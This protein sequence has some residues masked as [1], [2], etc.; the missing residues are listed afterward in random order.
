MES[1]KTDLE[2]NEAE[3]QTII[4]Q[5]QEEITR[6]DGDIEAQKSLMNKFTVAREEAERR[7][8]EISRQEMG[9]ANA[10]VRVRIRKMERY[11]TPPNIRA[12]SCGRY[13]P[14]VLSRMN[15]V[16]EMLL[17]REQVHIIRDLI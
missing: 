3:L 14:E 1:V 12:N 2:S 15:L 4:D 13:R 16:T 17:Q 7:I 6:Y 11:T 10:M 8:A 9:K 5:K